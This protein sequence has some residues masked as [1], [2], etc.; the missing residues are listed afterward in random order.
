MTAEL[1]LALL[2]AFLRQRS[3]RWRVMAVVFSAFLGSFVA[4]GAAGIVAGIMRAE[5]R[6]RDR[7][8]ILAATPSAGDLLLVERDDA[9]AGRQFAVVWIEPAS[10]AEPVLPP[11]LERLPAPGE[12][13][14]SPAL[15]RAIAEVTHLR[16]RYPRRSL[17]GESG[18]RT[19]NELIAYVRVPRGHTIAGDDRTLRAARFGPP[20]HG[21]AAW[22]IGIPSRASVPVV[23]AGLVA[24]VG[25]PAALVLA[26]AINASSPAL[27]SR[28]ELLAVLG[29][30]RRK[31]VRLTA[32]E[33]LIL[34]MPSI[35]LGAVT[36]TYVLRSAETIPLAG[37]PV[38]RGDIYPTWWG[39][40]AAIVAVGAF[41]V[42]VSTVGVLLRTRHTLSPPPRRQRWRQVPLVVALAA[43]AWVIT[44]GLGSQIGGAYSLFAAAVIVISAVPFV[45][46]GATRFVGSLLGGARPVSIHL[47]GRWLGR[48]ARDAARPFAAAGTL[49]AIALAV[50]G[51]SAVATASEER[52]LLAEETSGALIRWLDPRPGDIEVLASRLPGDLVVGVARSQDRIELGQRCDSIRAYVPTA[53][54]H[55]EVLAFAD[56]RYGVLATVLGAYGE[57]VVTAARYPWREALVISKRS[58]VELDRRMR[59]AAFGRL[60]APTVESDY[61]RGAVSE[62]TS[63]L[64]GGLAAAILL[65]AIATLIGV[66]DRLLARTA[67]LGVLEN[68]GIGTG[69]RRRIEAIQLLAPYGVSIGFGALCG[70]VVCISIVV[71]ADV[72]IP[73]TRLGFTLSAL[74]VGGAVTTLLVRASR[75]GAAIPH[76]PTT[77]P[78]SHA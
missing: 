57:R 65:A 72:A 58:P 53:T 17:I 77:W 66:V 56:K 68:L 19:A 6:A 54:C 37:L 18:V 10:S 47:A 69:G 40:G 75:F 21:Q 71:R 20:P 9:I 63:W 36:A 25:L 70:L 42:A 1:R 38:F 35:A 43:A 41:I 39:I 61:R 3:H 22:P 31:I 5:D 23:I 8:A 73:W 15:E 76:E 59:R 78:A 67:D 12:A 64:I 32:L 28:L 13:V 44:G 60:V 48:N 50:A 52:Q 29:L 33:S 34:A 55:G 51:Y 16:A 7:T 74:V 46:P 62:L 14:V 30:G 45:A 24:L 49:T 2:F 26:L 27:Q 11:G 4:V